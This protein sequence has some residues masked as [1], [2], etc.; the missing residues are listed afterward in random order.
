[1]TRSAAISSSSC[2][3][4]D[5]SPRALFRFV[6]FSDQIIYQCLP[7]SCPRGTSNHSRAATIGS[8]RVKCRLVATRRPSPIGPSFQ[9]ACPNISAKG[10]SA[11]DAPTT[12][13]NPGSYSP[14]PITF[15]TCARGQGNEAARGSSRYLVSVPTVSPPTFRPIF[16]DSCLPRCSS[17]EGSGPS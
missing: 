5:L 10:P 4:G 3:P 6:R 12:T 9:S 1:M 7:S 17:E 14:L 2:R 15:T 8:A 16:P 13:R 11:I